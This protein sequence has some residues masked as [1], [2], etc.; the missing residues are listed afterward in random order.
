VS[1]LLDVGDGNLVYWEEHGSGTPALMVHG[2]PGSGCGP[3][4]LDLFDLD[5][6]RVVLVDQRNCGRSRPHAS[7]PATDLKANTTRHL[8][9]DFERVRE[10]LGLDRWLVLGGSWGSTLA[11]AYAETHPERVSGLVVFGVT[12][13]RHS[14]FDW[15]FRGGVA[16]FFPQQWERLVAHVGAVDDVPAA[17]YRLLNDPDPQVRRRASEEWCLWESATPHWPPRAGMSDRYA[18]PDYAYAFARLVTHYIQ[19]NAWLQDGELIRPD[20][21]EG[22]PGAIVNGGFDFQAPVRNAWTLH[23]AWPRA[24]L[25]I[26]EASGHALNPSLTGAIRA[27]TDRLSS[28]R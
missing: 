17:Y 1:G 12:T 2:G 5:A 4:H 16:L 18:D 28:A 20:V 24:E 6:Y 8:V 27:A 15:L 9:A 10:H 3:H 13:G 7:D 22:I 23:R 11:L 21:L 25:T 26:S 14:E 19:S